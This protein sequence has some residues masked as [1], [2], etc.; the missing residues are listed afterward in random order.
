MSVERA[1]KHFWTVQLG[2]S[3]MLLVWQEAEEGHLV[4]EQV[5]AY[6]AP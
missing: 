6:V 2:R 4:V 1:L 3:R 5:R